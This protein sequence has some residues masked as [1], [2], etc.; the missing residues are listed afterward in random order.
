[1]KKSYRKYHDMK[2]KYE[3]LKFGHIGKNSGCRAVG[4]SIE[5]GA[6]CLGFEFWFCY[7]RTTWPTVPRVRRIKRVNIY[8]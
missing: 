1:M 4:K 7:F 2:V 8:I 5:S 6:R 3:W